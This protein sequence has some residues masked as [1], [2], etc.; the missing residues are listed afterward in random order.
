MASADMSTDD[1]L[2]KHLD[3]RAGDGMRRHD[4]W[5]LNSLSNRFLKLKHNMI[6]KVNVYLF[7][8]LVTIQIICWQQLNIGI[9]TQYKYSFTIPVGTQ[10]ITVVTTFKKYTD[11]LLQ[12]YLFQWMEF[13]KNDP[14]FYCTEIFI[15][16]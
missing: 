14:I 6:I 1:T 9:Q 5:V 13:K 12:I 11:F 10:I 4:Y 15:P 16:A 2:S 3:T 7:T 8:I